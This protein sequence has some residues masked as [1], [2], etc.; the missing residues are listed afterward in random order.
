LSGRSFFQF[1]S[2]RV[3]RSYACD[4]EKEGKNQVIEVKAVPGRMFEL[5]GKGLPERAAR[6]FTHHVEDLFP[7]HD[8][9]HIES[10]KGVKGI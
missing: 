8:P 5:V 2:D 9:E 7:T 4:E 3:W 10:P 1:P 6:V